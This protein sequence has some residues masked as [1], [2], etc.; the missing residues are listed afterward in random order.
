MKLLQAREPLRYRQFQYQFGGFAVSVIGNTLSQV[1]LTIGLLQATGSAT[2]AGIALTASTLTLVV[3]ILFGGV[4]ADRLP[5]NLVMAAMDLVRGVVQLAVG[6][7]LLSGHV[8][9]VPLVAL[10]IVFGAAQA[11][12]LPASSGLTR[13]T[14]PKEQ[15]QRANALLSFTRSTAGVVGPLLAG[16]LIATVGAGWALVGDGVS[17]LGSAL[18]AALIKLPR[19]EPRTDSSMFRELA[20]GFRLVRTSPWI[21]TSIAGFMCTHVAVAVFMVIGPVMASEGGGAL[22]WS[23][24]IAALGVGDILG[25]LL[26]LRFQPR[27]PLL[28]ARCAELL[29]APALVLVALGAHPVVQVVAVAFAGAGMTA[30]DSLWL[31]TMQHQVP[32]ES[33]SKVS[34][35]D[36]LSSVALRP[37]GYALGAAAGT[38]D[39]AGVLCALAVL[40]LLSRLVSLAYPSVRHLRTP[41][42]A[43]VHG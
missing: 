29:L 33:L 26:L 25:D 13:F 18:C 15:I 17:F 38:G 1:A 37:L 10:Q 42:D 21:W 4:W 22:K 39:V 12:H 41:A 19:R 20:E 40:V 35:Y 31:T 5:R 11:F 30:A 36:W 43:L 2:T 7:M 16:A 23:L 9:L 27:R 14:V 28:V 34:S 24:L 8:S 32:D 6:A 3:C